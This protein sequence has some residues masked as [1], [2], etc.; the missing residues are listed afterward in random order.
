MSLQEGYANT[1]TTPAHYRAVKHCLQPSFSVSHSFASSSAIPVRDLQT[2]HASTAEEHKLPNNTAPI[3]EH[4]PSWA[5]GAAELRPAQHQVLLMG[6]KGSG[7]DPAFWSLDWQDLAVLIWW[8][9]YSYGQLANKA[10]VSI[11]SGALG[12]KEGGA[13]GHLKATCVKT[14]GR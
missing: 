11:K 3:T 13:A 9:L 14:S 2:P 10:D 1:T 4:R 6:R 12:R 5:E 8:L 7:E